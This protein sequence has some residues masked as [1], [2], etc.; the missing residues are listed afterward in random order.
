M[1]P[2]AVEEMVRQTE[3]PGLEDASF[4]RNQIGWI[5]QSSSSWTRELFRNQARALENE[6]ELMQ[7]PDVLKM[8]QTHRDSMLRSDPVAVSHVRRFLSTWMLGFNPAT[9]MI[10]GTQLLT[11]GATEMT[12]LTGK[13]IDSFR[14]ML[15]GFKEATGLTKPSPEMAKEREWLNRQ[16]KDEGI[17]SA[18]NEG[19]PGNDGMEALQQALSRGRAQTKGQ[20]L[21]GIHKAVNQ[22]AMWMFQ[23]AEKINNNGAI[24]A[25]FDYHMEQDGVRNLTG[26][27]YEDARQA[28]YEKA[29]G[30][31]QTV[32]DVGGRANRPIWAFSG[33]D[34][35]SRSAGVLG[36]AMQ[37]YNVGT[38][39]QIA[40]YI[41]KG[42]YDPAGL[43][44]G[45]KHNARV[46]L[47]Q[48]L[49]VQTAMAGMLG[50]PFAG[51]AVAIN[52]VFRSSKSTRTSSGIIFW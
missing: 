16:I 18:F 31:N 26:K 4:V 12:S 6:P 29:K 50:V 32:N 34:D 14:R 33:K 45:E 27:A 5:D 8:L 20:Q 37:T 21:D 9:V 19:D 51:S 38:I 30:F 36:M 47:V 39:N 43:K 40:N 3:Q 2:D 24:L 11:R 48:L 52:Q 44:P 10:N 13:P 28:A 41:R 46:A 22:K 49:A 15:S 35:F 1:A 23:Q 42:F 25:A 7:R 17:V